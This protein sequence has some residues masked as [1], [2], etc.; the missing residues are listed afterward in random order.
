M[1][2]RSGYTGNGRSPGFD[3][4]NPGFMD[5][6]RDAYMSSSGSWMNSYDGLSRESYY[7]RPEGGRFGYSGPQGGYE[8]RPEQQPPHRGQAGWRGRGRGGRFRS[9][10]SRFRHSMS[11]QELYPELNTFSNLEE[12]TKDFHFGGGIKWYRERGVKNKPYDEDDDDDEEEEEPAVKKM[13]TTAEKKEHEESGSEE[14][15]S[16]AEEAAESTT[17][18][19]NQEDGKQKESEHAQSSSKSQQETKS[20]NI[21]NKLM[22]KILLSCS[23]C[24]FC[25]FY[26]EKMNNHLQS[27]FHK[28]RYDY[29][30][31]NLPRK[32]ATFLQE[33][34]SQKTKKTEEQR[35]LV[36]DL[37]NKIHKIYQSRDLTLGLGM[38]NFVKK[39]DVANCVACSILIP[40]QPSAIERHIRTSLHSKKC[41][42]MMENSK[43]RALRLARMMLSNLD[44]K[45]EQ[46]INSHKDE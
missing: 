36:P 10:P 44:Q 17:T 24:D 28:K 34:M 30:G 43:R 11:E 38:E 21:G 9:T 32:K 18:D 31:E 23:F 14:G 40:M 27:D 4:P 42:T 15:E 39:I 5:Y 16:A 20:R 7:D 35:K 13:K 45:V 29:L 8:R 12:F 3:F 19:G 25:T 33:H 22:H 26:E 1:Y 41:K 2:G 6:G 37:S 46:Y